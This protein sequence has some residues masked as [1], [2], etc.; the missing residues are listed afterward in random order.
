M[1]VTYLNTVFKYTDVLMP[2]T[3][4]E[5]PGKTTLV[6]NSTSWDMK[7]KTFQHLKH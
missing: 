5:F 6:K 4:E 3:Y 7:E 1:S 2:L